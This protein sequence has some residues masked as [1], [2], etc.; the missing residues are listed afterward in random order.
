MQPSLPPPAPPEAHCPPLEDLACLVDGVLGAEEAETTL[1]HVLDC[2][3]CYE[4]YAG[5]LRFQLEEPEGD[6]ETGPNGVPIPSPRPGPG[7]ADISAPKPSPRP[8]PAPRRRRGTYRWAA[9]AAGLVLASALAYLLHTQAV[10]RDGDL[11][12]D[13]ALL[14][15][16]HPEALQFG[17]VNDK[18]VRSAPNP[19]GARPE[20]GAERSIRIGALLTDLELARR[21]DAPQSVVRALSALAGQVN[22]SPDGDGREIDLR[23][24]AVRADRSKSVKALEREIAAAARALRQGAPRTRRYVA[25]GEWAEALRLFAKA[26]S[27]RFFTGK[28]RELLTD[29]LSDPQVQGRPLDLGEEIPLALLEIDRLWPD[30][31]N[32]APVDYGALSVAFGQILGIEPPKPSASP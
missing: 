25:L 5:L 27:P 14:A 8:L 13:L 11:A 2:A 15:E 4:I 22:G 10:A 24:L 21:I 7:Q 1:R 29:L 18:T 17:L 9:L 12:P 19:E 6:V 16:R 20:A 26:G 28:R 23:R 3:R 30:P 31:A 32:P